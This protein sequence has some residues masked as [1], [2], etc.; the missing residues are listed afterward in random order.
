MR[1]KK[2]QQN[3]KTKVSCKTVLKCKVLKTAGNLR[4]WNSNHTA[5]SAPIREVET[6]NLSLMISCK[7]A[8]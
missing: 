7:Y 8:L 2:K 1:K 3:R 5:S 6:T 4:T